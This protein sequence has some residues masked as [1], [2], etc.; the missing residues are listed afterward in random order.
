MVDCGM[1]TID[2]YKPKGGYVLGN[3]ITELRLAKPLLMGDFASGV[4]DSGLND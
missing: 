4:V 1:A 2:E 3:N